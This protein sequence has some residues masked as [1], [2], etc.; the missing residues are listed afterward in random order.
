MTPKARELAHSI[1]LVGSFMLL[2]LIFVDQMI[3]NP[4]A[5]G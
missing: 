2:G 5:L 3:G 1:L 4:M